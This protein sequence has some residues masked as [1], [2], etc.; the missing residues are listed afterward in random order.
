MTEVVTSVPTLRLR[1]LQ[2][3][4][5]ATQKEW[6]K[7]LQKVAWMLEHGGK[8]QVKM[9][10]PGRRRSR[11]LRT[12]DV[13]TR[14]ASRHSYVARLA[15]NRG[16]FDPISMMK[17]MPEPQKLPVGIRREEGAF[18]ATVDEF[19]GVFA[20]GDDRDELHES[21]QEGIALILAQPGQVPPAVTLG[22]LH[23]EPVAMTAGA[24]LIYA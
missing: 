12:N 22:E 17:A 5:P 24:E 2:R 14:R 15:C 19:P 21:T 10:K 13:R 6:I 7:R 20:T 9:T 11:C 23:V 16:S 1:T 4:M 18:W 3:L 8:H